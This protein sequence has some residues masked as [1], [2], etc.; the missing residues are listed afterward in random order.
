MPRRQR[1]YLPGLPTISF[2]DAYLLE[3]YRY[4]ALNPVRALGDERFRED[5]EAEL[6]VLIGQQA[7]GR[8]R[9][10]AARLARN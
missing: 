4:I 8:A 1:M 3:C 6:G 5:V 9:K 10:R 7:R 2:S